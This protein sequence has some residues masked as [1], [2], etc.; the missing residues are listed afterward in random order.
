MGLE[1]TINALRAE[2]KHLQST[3]NLMNQRI[4]ELELNID[5]KDKEI[6]ILKKNTQSISQL[7]QDNRFVETLK[8]DLVE[9]TKEVK[10]IPRKLQQKI[11]NFPKK[12]RKIQ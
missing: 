10:K 1:D 4:N 11:R 2:N 3:I 9:R 6:L 7:Q 5:T 8:N 12:L